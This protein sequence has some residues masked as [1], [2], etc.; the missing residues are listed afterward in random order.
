MRTK[1]AKQTDN[2]LLVGILDYMA[3]EIKGE[4][5][6]DTLNTED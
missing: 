6:F 2:K 4:F 5:G 1:F 3:Q